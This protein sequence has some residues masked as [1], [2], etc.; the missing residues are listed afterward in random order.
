MT[1]S[2][3]W[4]HDTFCC[5]LLMEYLTM[6]TL[7]RLLKAAAIRLIGR[8]RRSGTKTDRYTCALPRGCLVFF[9]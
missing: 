5:L 8:G 1:S 6:K 9:V 4:L 3:E 7:L 2:E